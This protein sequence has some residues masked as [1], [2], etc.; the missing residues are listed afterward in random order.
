MVIV[1]CDNSVIVSALNSKS[2]KGEAIHPLQLI[3][4]AAALNDIEL[5]SEWLSTKEN[6]IA[7]ALSRFQIDK[8]ANLFPQFQGL[9]S[10]HHRETGKPISELRAKLQAYFGMDSLPVLETATRL[11]STNSNSL[12]TAVV[13]NHSPH[14]SH[15]SQIGMPTQS[16][17]HRRRRLKATS[18]HYGATT[19]T[20]DSQQQYSMMNVSNASFVGPNGSMVQ[21]Q[22]ERGRKSLRRYWKR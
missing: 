2:V 15:Y 1:M 10:P 14:P 4:L 17:R 19:L 7:D 6:W 8:V 5:F 21:H 20:L 22:H 9:S 3:F 13:S 11:P 16:Q 12:P 18:Q